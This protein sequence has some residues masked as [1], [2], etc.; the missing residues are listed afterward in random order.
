MILVILETAGTKVPKGALAIIQAAL[1]AKKIHGHQKAVGLILGGSDSAEAA[2][3][4]AGFGLDE[5]LY[6]SS[7]DLEP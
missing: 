3:N 6:I 7:P 4:A 5:I 2:N 1:D